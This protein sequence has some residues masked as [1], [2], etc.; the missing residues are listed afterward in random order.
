MNW[1][2]A[3]LRSSTLYHRVVSLFIVFVI[4]GL[5]L[6][7]Y[8]VVFRYRHRNKEPDSIEV[9]VGI[10]G[11]HFMLQNT[12]FVSTVAVLALFMSRLVRTA[13]STNRD[14]DLHCSLQEGWSYV[15]GIYFSVVT[16]LT[17]GFGD[18]SP[19]R[20][21]TQIVL[22][23]F[24]IVG[25]VQVALLIEMIVTFVSSRERTRR[26]RRRAAYERMRQEDMDRRDGDTNLAKE[27]KF[28]HEMNESA[29]K[30]KIMR[31][32]AL[33]MSG[34]VLFWVLGAIIFSQI[35]VRIPPDETLE[36]WLDFEF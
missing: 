23:P 21:V 35:E 31:D 1:S 3:H 26:A 24:T 29:Y 18:F 27:M 11:R 25:I 10:A 17:I 4:V 2:I 28:L 16:F 8:V 36:A 34:F 15:E 14:D 5:L 30:L 32:L 7:H 6:F 20:T 13:F 19:T 22:F 12:V 9:Q 33:N